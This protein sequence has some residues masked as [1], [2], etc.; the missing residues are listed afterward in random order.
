MIR[1]RCHRLNH[2]VGIILHIN[3]VV[4]VYTSKPESGEWKFYSIIATP[5]RY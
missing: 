5:V 2:T 1:E 3:Y 4:S